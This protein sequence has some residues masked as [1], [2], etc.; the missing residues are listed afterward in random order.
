M[1]AAVARSTLWRRSGRMQSHDQLYAG[2]ANHPSHV[3]DHSETQTLLG[4]GGAAGT[5]FGLFV[6]LRFG[7]SSQAPNV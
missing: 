5:G 1:Q 4:P 7:A 3:G 2:Y 6:N